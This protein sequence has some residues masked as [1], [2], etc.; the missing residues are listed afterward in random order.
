MLER[1]SD[2]FILRGATGP[3]IRTLFAALAVVAGVGFSGPAS[4]STGHLV[5]TVLG[6]L[7]DSGIPFIQLTL[8][9]LA[10]I[11]VALLLIR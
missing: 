8:G 3:V 7:S 11:V 10:V 9:C 2:R 5:A 6:W 1:V 4:A